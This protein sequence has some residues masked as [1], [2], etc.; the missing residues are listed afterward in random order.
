MPRISGKGQITKPIAE[1]NNGLIVKSK[2]ENRFMNWF[3]RGKR[4]SKREID[5][6]V[7]EIQ[8]R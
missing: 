2:R 4:W 6:M 7:K 8:G 5:Q 1:E 3:G